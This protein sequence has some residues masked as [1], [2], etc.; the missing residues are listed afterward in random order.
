VWLTGVVRT[1]S[2]EPL[3]LVSPAP[4][5][6][7]VVRVTDVAWL[8]D[9]RVVVLGSRRRDDKRLVVQPWVVDVGGDPTE[10][11]VE[12][13]ADLGQIVVGAD[14]KPVPTPDAWERLPLDVA[15]TLAVGN[16]IEAVFVAGP[17][18]DLFQYRSAGTWERRVTVFRPAF[19]G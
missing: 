6:P 2:G 9:R 19:P 14:G 18:G 5:L 17:R 3:Q 4:L 8:D 1:R 15:P 11:G 7:D 10:R 12:A 16:G 13:T